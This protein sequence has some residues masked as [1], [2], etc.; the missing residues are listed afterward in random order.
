MHA[1]ADD[2]DANQSPDSESPDSVTPDS[3]T[4]A[5]V[6]FGA[7]LGNAVKQF[8][9]VVALLQNEGTVLRV[10]SHYR[11]EPA[12]GPNDQPPYLNAAVSLNVEQTADEFLGA[13]H[14]IEKELGRVRQAHWG[15]RSVDLDLV[16]FG[17]ETRT[18]PTAQSNLLLPH[19]RM[20]WRRF[21]L[22]P[23]VEIEPDW[24][25]PLLRRTIQ[26]LEDRLGEFS[27][28]GIIADVEEDAQQVIDEVPSPWRDAPLAANPTD[29]S[30]LS[31]AVV[32]EQDLAQTVELWNRGVPAIA[33]GNRDYFAAAVELIGAIAAAQLTHRT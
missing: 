28:Y 6:A 24:K 33:I 10:S 18:Q 20:A 23:A 2:A 31:M 14:R 4:K 29:V 11:T 16:L 17:E 12:G 13:L 7:N 21:V 22:A 26:Q 25:H 5:L 9:Q 3:Q 32:I 1:P 30:T 15:A 8:D 19:P 27:R